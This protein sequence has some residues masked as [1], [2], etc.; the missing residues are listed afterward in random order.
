M[1]HPGGSCIYP[2]ANMRVNGIPDI[3]NT[4]VLGSLV[5]I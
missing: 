3:M 5:D 1:G 2:V 4:P